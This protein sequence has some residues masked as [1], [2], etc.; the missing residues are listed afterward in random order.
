MISAANDY[1]SHI[2]LSS[3]GGPVFARPISIQDREELLTAFHEASPE[4]I[5]QRFFVPLQ[6][7]S[8]EQI[9]YLIDVDQQ[10]HVAWALF[11]IDGDR[12]KGVA[13][14]RFVKLAEEKDVA[15]FSLTVREEYQKNGY[16]TL[17]LSLLLKLAREHRLTHLIGY[18]HAD[19]I[20]LLHLVRKFEATIEDEEGELYKV[21]LPV[22]VS[23]LDRGR[24][25][26]QPPHRPNAHDRA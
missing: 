25:T 15:E 21:T 3:K 20:P 22:P 6:D 16:G 7:L 10:K 23:Q 11:R 26:T 9:T 14:G 18:T 19:N 13:A 12:I 2:E 1:P 24:G 5:Y 17:M 4:T 8:E